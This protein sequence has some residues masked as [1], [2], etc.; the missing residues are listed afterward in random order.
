M[1]LEFVGDCTHG[2]VL[3][4]MFVRLYGKNFSRITKLTKPACRDE[5]SPYERDIPPFK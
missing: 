5:N 3:N 1:F 2:V 4:K